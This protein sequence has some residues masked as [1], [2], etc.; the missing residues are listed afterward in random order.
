[1]QESPKEPW[2]I[3]VVDDEKDV[4]AV[5][6]LALKR[7]MWRDRGF[8][9]E[10]AHTAAEAR[11]L[12]QRYGH[13]FHV[14][15]ID[16]V[17]ET[18]NAGLE[19]CEFI[20]STFASAIRI[21]LRTGQPGLAPELEV[22]E[23]Y[24]IDHYLAKAEA[25]ETRLF[26]LVRS[27]L[28]TFEDLTALEEANASLTVTNAEMQRRE[29]VHQNVINELEESSGRIDELLGRLHSVDRGSG[30]ELKRVA[31]ALSGISTRV[32][33][34]FTP[35]DF[36]SQVESALENKSV[37]LLLKTGKALRLTKGALAGLNASTAIAGSWEDGLKALRT[38]KI[39][40]LFVDWENLGV[41]NEAVSYNPSLLAVLLTSQ[42]LFE[43]HG[44]TIMS[45]PISSAIVIS[46]LLGEGDEIDPLGVQELVITAG[47]LISKDIFGLEKYLAWGVKLRELHIRHSD[48][49]LEALQRI[50]EFSKECELR[51]SMRQ[52]LATLT[53]ELLMNAIWDAPVDSKGNTKYAQLD[54]KVP[55][56]LLPEEEVMLRY[57]SDGN[58]LALSVTDNFGR[59]Q[60][61]TAFKYLMRCFSKG[62]D[63]ISQ[64]T[65][66]AGLG[67]YMAYLAMS[68]FV[69][70]CHPGKRT[71]VIG[72]LNLRV[73]PREMNARPRSFH[74]FIG[75]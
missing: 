17:M 29:H 14:A 37:L 42:S 7:K 57:G 74:Y 68:T 64:T 2:S 62:R 52:K 20:R 73:S 30:D 1:M 11:Q 54:R 28:K 33:S 15:I 51:G 46:S 56:E 67:L 75:R 61:E 3:L 58:Y 6:A 70:N 27:C 38:G 16:V 45:L 47:K 22:L 5:T 39:D 13:K 32:E 48:Q 53:E 59:L 9:L 69:I 50:E 60:R 65:G 12:L 43:E 31:T 4:H 24:D 40:L 34:L 21:I 26:A 44:K 63:Q 8:R 36:H 18:D 72:L 49:R 55:V 23:T 10:H 71:E 41:L 25:T 35:R 66:G 19:L